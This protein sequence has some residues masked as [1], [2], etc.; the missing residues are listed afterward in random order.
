MTD[1]A[2]IG[3]NTGPMIDPAEQDALNRYGIRRELRPHYEVDGYQYTKL[4]D[5]VAQARRTRGA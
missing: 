1:T 4:A 2:P 3:R 5:A